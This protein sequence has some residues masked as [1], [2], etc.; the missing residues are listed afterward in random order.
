MTKTVLL[1]RP[2]PF[3]AAE[4]WRFMEETGYTPHKL[5]TMQNLST[6]VG[7]ASGVV[8]SLALSSGVGESAED[9]YQQVRKISTRIPVLFAAMLPFEKVRSSLDRIVN[10]GRRPCDAQAT[11]LGLDALSMAGSRLGRSGSQLYFSKEDLAAIE[12]RTV[13]AKLIRQHFQ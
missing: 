2:H 4:M 3:I 5:E 9:V 8:I 11:V 12:R 10:Q 6:L 13:A 1:A 7:S